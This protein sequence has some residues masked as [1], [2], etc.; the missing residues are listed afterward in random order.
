MQRADEKNLANDE[1][2]FT[3]ELQKHPLNNVSVT[4]R[5]FKYSNTE[6][7]LSCR[8]IYWNSKMANISPL[9]ERS[10]ITKVLSKRQLNFCKLCQ[11]KKFYIIKSLNDPN[12]LNN[13]S[14]LV[15][16][17]FNKCFKKNRYKERS[18][19]MD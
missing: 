14:E 12:L 10:I 6:I 7:A 15:N 16:T 5:Y 1:K 13:K 19:T 8:N 2:N 17:C 11:S 18:D 9:I 3:L 4:T